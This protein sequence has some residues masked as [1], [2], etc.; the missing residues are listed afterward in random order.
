MKFLKK[1]LLVLLLVFLLGWIFLTTLIHQAPMGWLVYQAQQGWISRYLPAQ[2][3]QQVKQ[4]DAQ[5][6]EGHLG[7]GQARDLQMA[8]AEV[9]LVKWQLPWWRLALLQ[10]RLDVQ[11]GEEPLPWQVRLALSPTGSV[12]LGVEAGSLEV[13]QGLPV[14]LQGRLEGQ[15]Q[16]QFQ[17]QEGQ[18]QCLEFQGNWQGVIRLKNPM[19][20]D[21][22]RVGLEPACP[23]V[24]ELH[25]HATSTIADE[26]ELELEGQVTTERWSFTGEAWVD[27]TAQMATLLR[28]LGWR[29]QS[30]AREGESAPGQRLEAKG[31]GRF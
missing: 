9:A 17:V 10:P 19:T 25:W 28:M 22:G 13:I 24:D 21:L 31:S 23:A 29:N 5:A 18:L 2:T 30:A 14:T 20:V 1:A 11:L 26:H 7:R 3:L 16:A 27:E 8:G 4:L 6:F 15:L 12:K